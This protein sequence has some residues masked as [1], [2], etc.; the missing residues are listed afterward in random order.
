MRKLTHQEIVSRQQ[1]KVAES[2]L[3]LVAVLDNIR[4]LHNVGSIFRSADGVGVEKIWLCGI[5]GYPPQS[6]I[7][8]TAI[9][10]E[11]RVSW[12]HSLDVKQVVRELKNQGYQ[13]VLLEQMDESVV[14]YEFV[15]RGPICLVIGNEKEGISDEL[16]ALSDDAIEIAMNGIKNSLNVSVA[17]GVVACHISRFLKQ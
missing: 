13:I 3:P 4:S 8:K 1:L 2:C 7:T 6:Q 17:F 10:A 14:Y 12:E 16:V 5:T 11:D 15:P 9:G